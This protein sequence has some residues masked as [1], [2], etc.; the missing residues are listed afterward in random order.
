MHINNCIHLRR[1]LQKRWF[2]FQTL[3]KSSK[4]PLIEF[5]SLK[6]NTGLSGS[7]A[8]ADIIKKQQYSPLLL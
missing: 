4:Y 5:P 2:K 7:S 6:K 8:V 3:I 1:I